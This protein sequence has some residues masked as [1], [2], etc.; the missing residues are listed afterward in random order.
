MRL[1]RVDGGWRRSPNPG[2][3]LQ[4][5]RVAGK[6]G[7]GRAGEVPFLALDTFFAFVC[8]LIFSYLSGYFFFP[9]LLW[10][11]LFRVSRLIFVCVLHLTMDGCTTV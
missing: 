5:G 6:E 4:G 7:P 8:P 10:C 9:A 1:R 11:G 3:A 2:T